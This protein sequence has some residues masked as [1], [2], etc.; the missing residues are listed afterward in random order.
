ME[1]W[2]GKLI[3]KNKEDASLSVIDLDL[4]FSLFG[5][6]DGHGGNKIK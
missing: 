4:N 3:I 2:N 1:K 5:V 6:F